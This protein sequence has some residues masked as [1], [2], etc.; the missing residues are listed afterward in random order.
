MDRKKFLGTGASE[1]DKHNK[2]RKKVEI[3]ESFSL[4][5]PINNLWLIDGELK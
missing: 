3:K 2:R 1:K 5:L 4:L